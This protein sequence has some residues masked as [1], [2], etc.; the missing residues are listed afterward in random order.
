MGPVTGF[1]IRAETE[2]GFDAETEFVGGTGSGFCVETESAIGTESEFDAEV[3]LGTETETGTE[4]ENASFE[5]INSFTVGFT[6]IVSRFLLA[7]RL[8]WRCTHSQG[9][10]TPCAAPC[11]SMR[12]CASLGP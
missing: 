5:E 9:V 3:G 2:T 1:G 11:S 8:V 6:P 4:S 7:S 12:R 10:H